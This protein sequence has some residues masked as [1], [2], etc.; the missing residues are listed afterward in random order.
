MSKTP[1][2]GKLC[3]G[4]VMNI[5]YLCSRADVYHLRRC[6]PSSTSSLPPSFPVHH[7]N[8]V[9][10]RGRRISHIF[11]CFFFF[12]FPF[13]PSV[14]S[15]ASL[16]HPPSPPLILRLTS[17]IHHSLA[18]LALFFSLSDELTLELRDDGRE[19]GVKERRVR[20]VCTCVCVCV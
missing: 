10:R 12:F 15:T 16:S 11:F 4:K 6:K 14:S 3:V 5:W 2:V 19:V 9:I 7:R 18:H 1:G 13:S 8:P 20:T 17:F